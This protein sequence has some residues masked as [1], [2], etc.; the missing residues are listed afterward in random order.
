MNW[1]LLI[2]MVSFSLRSAFEW[3]R[4]RSP[5]RKIDRG[6]EGERERERALE[7]K[8]GWFHGRGARPEGRG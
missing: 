2:K 7:T 3:A 5:F 1:Q 6:R 8:R 4:A